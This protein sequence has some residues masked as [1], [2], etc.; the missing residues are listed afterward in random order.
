MEIYIHRLCDFKEMS[1]KDFMT[2]NVCII[3]HEFMLCW[4][5]MK[6]YKNGNQKS[7]LMYMYN[8]NSKLGT[9]NKKNTLIGKQENMSLCMFNLCAKNEKPTK[10]V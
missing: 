9:I 10:R 6:H 3:K 1:T 7:Q 8:N 5:L 2:N 4:N